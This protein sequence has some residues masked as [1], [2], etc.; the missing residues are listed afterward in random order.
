MSYKSKFNGTK[1][2][3]LLTKVEEGAVGG[4]GSSVDDDA[5]MAKSAGMLYK[6][7]IAY[8]L[9]MG[10]MKGNY[11]CTVYSPDQTP[12]THETFSAWL[13]DTSMGLNAVRGNSFVQ[14]GGM[15]SQSPGL[16]AV[17]EESGVSAPAFLQPN[18]FVSG[19][20]SFTTE[21]GGNGISQLRLLDYTMN[22][23]ELLIGMGA[24]FTDTVTEL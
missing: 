21:G 18:T 13:S 19:G 15:Y 5:I 17:A 20:F 16:F 6:H 8:S 10:G 7:L 11:Y 1:I 23:L 9:D 3:E 14:G 2:D 4:G 22:P 24:T 12:F